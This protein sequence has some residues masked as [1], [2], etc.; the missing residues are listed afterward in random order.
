MDA[1]FLLD[2]KI[3]QERISLKKQWCTKIPYEDV[4]DEMSFLFG[5]AEDERLI[6]KMNEKGIDS[7]EN[8]SARKEDKAEEK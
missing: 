6:K 4:P 2:A 3:G 1:K 5:S 7:S 8:E